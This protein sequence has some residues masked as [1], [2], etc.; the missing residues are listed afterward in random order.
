MKK[1]FRRIISSALLCFCLT[2]CEQVLNFLEGS[3]LDKP[4]FDFKDVSLKSL[5]SEGLTLKCEYDI[6]NPYSVNLN[7][8]E[9]NVSVDC[10][11]NKFT[12]IKASE[13]IS[14]AAN[15][16][17]TNTF[18]C[19]IPYASL[20]NFAKSYGNATDKL[21][22]NFSGNI[23]LSNE[24]L[25]GLSIPFKKSINAP[26][27]KPSFSASSPTLFWPSKTEILTAATNNIGVIEATSF[28]TNLVQGTVD[29]A[30][31]KKLNLNLKLNFNLDV[32]NN[33]GSAWKYL[34]KSCAINTT[35]AVDTN[36][37]AF[38][39]IDTSAVSEIS[40]SSGSIPLTAVLNTVTAGDFIASIVKGTGSNP[41]F[42]LGS[43]V[44]FPGL[45]ETLGKL[46]IPLNYEMELPLSSITNS[47]IN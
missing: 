39:K 46:E 36:P 24:L 32:A 9:V 20:L 42:N 12:D 41:K 6:T 30:T 1:I 19:K 23:G 37:D 3:E 17:K 44:K 7:V 18:D 25:P 10:D 34:L 2:S 5:D 38:I 15:S 11:S 47:V 4:T 26:V 8:S 45:G 14:M 21:P 43:G 13:G 35:G 28:V 40:N 16:K 22:F 33:G 31:L 27:V 29:V